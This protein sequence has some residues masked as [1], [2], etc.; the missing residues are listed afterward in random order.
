MILSI[1]TKDQIKLIYSY[2][3][4]STGTLDDF[5]NLWGIT[6][7]NLQLILKQARENLLS[8]KQELNNEFYKIK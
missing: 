1:L 7:S 6:P 5:A 2:W 4:N 8:E 3:T